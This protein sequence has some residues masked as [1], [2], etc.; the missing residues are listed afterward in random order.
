LIP[1]WSMYLVGPFTGL[2][3]SF[4]HRSVGH[5]LELDASKSRDQL[6]LRYTPL[7]TTVRDMVVAME[8]LG[9]A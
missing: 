7:E 5:S 9:M 4:I 2:K 8:E 6:G 3:W 1:K